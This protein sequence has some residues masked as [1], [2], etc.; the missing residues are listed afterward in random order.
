M[1]WTYDAPLVI[2][3]GPKPLGIVKV[4]HGVTDASLSDGR[5][6]RL[7]LHLESVKLNAEDKLDISYSVV[8]EIMDEPINS[9]CEIH[10][11]VQ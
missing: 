10:E 9:I 6:V 11:T 1:K 4:K 5:L 3:L 2:A 8:T 7:S